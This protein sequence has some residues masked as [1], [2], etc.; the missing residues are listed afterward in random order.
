MNLEYRTIT[1]QITGNTKNSAMGLSSSYPDRTESNMHQNAI[2]P[3]EQFREV[4]LIIIK[5]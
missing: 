3:E 5:L 1:T 2:V 4:N